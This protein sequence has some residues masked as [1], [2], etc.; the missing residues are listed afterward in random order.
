VDRVKSSPRALTAQSPSPRRS[1]VEVTSVPA[2]RQ[3]QLAGM[4]SGRY[5]SNAADCEARH[6]RAF[7][8]GASRDRTGDL[9]LAK[10]TRADFGYWPDSGL[11]ANG[12]FSLDVQIA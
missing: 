8:S 1:S 6:S 2:Q 9:L 7:V 3:A 12:W 5:F 10:S 11:R 4:R